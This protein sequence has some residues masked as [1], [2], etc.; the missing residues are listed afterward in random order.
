LIAAFHQVRDAGLSGKLPLVFWDEFDSTLNNIELGW[1]RYFLEPMQDGTFLEGQVSHPIGRAIFVFAGGTR[2]TFQEFSQSEMAKNLKK[3]KDVKGPDFVSRLRGFLNILGPN[4]LNRSPAADPCHVVRRSIL[5]RS[6]L[7]RGCPGLVKGGKLQIDEGVLGAFLRV[8]S[9]RHGARSMESLIAAS[10]LSGKTFFGRSC[11]PP[12]AQLNLHVDGIEFQTLVEEMDGM[13]NLAQALHENYC[14]KLTD[15]HYVFGDKSDEDKKISNALVSFE[16][17]SE[18]LK[19]ENRR[20]AKELPRKLAAVGYAILPSREGL[21]AVEFPPEILERLAELEHDRWVFNKLKDGW[22]YGTPRDNP[23]KIHPAL[24][25]W[26]DITP[27]ERLKLYPERPE[28]V[29]LT[30]LPET[31]KDKD[32]DQFVGLSAMLV[33][34]GCAVVKLTDPKAAK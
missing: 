16:Q 3:F 28:R 6:M 23:K 19:E 11:L 30:A 26:R 1:L 7:K 31:E 13:E 24:L 9:Y 18:E 34:Y 10:T 27:D 25:P 4:P 29:G 21:P 5:L 17:L 12:F 22:K 14:K 15:R 8:S 2:A 33:Q 32:R 20:A